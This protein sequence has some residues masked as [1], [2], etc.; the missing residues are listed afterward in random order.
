MPNQV[1]NLVH[2]WNDTPAYDYTSAQIL[3]DTLRDGLQSP[4]AHQPTYH[5]K[6]TFR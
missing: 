5:R 3:D 4:T 2:E 6:K 1:D